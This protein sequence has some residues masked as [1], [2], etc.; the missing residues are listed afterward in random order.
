MPLELK[1]FRGHIAFSLSVCNA[2]LVKRLLKASKCEF[3]MSQV[4]Y[5]GHIVS[6]EGIQTDPEKTSAIRDWPVPQ[7]VKDVRS[8][9]EFMGYYRCFIQN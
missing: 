6:Q 8:F 4:T 9:L 3:M 1:I 2:Y 7:N 5:L